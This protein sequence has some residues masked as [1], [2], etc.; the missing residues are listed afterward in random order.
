MYRRLLAELARARRWEVHFYDARDVVD[1][2]VGMLGERAD[3][4]LR[5]PRA[6]IGPPWARDHR[7][8]LAAT[9]VAAGR[10]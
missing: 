9:I 1:Q 7:V 10:A 2:A 5:G 6:S 8:A 3:G 4:V